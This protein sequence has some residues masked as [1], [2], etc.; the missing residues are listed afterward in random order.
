MKS[1]IIVICFSVI[2]IIN[3]SATAVT[4]T[5]H[6]DWDAPDTGSNS[7]PAFYDF[8]GDGDTDLLV[9]M[10]NGNMWAYKN[11]GSN[12]N[13]AWTRYSDWDAPDTGNDSS[14][15]FYDFDADGDTD[16]LA[17]MSTGRM[18]A[19]KNTGSDNDP[20]W[21]RYSD[22]DA[23]ETGSNASPAFYDFDGDGDTD[24]LVGMSN[25]N[26]WAYKNTGSD[27][28]PTWT[29]HSDWD[30]P[31]TGNDSTPAFYDFD[32][33]GDTDIL[34]GMSTGN[35]WAYEACSDYSQT[36]SVS[37]ST[38]LSFNELPSGDGHY[39]D[40]TFTNFSGSG[41][42]TVLETNMA[43]TNSP[44]KSPLHLRWD[45]DISAG[46][47]NFSCNVS[48]HYDDADV[49]GYPESSAYL[50]IAKYSSSTNTWQWVGGAVNADNNTVTVSGVTSFS[51]F[52]LFRRIFGDITG[53]G[54][55]DAADLQRLGDC[56]HATNSG[57]FTGGSD[58]R[59][60]NFNKNTDGGSQIIDAADLQ[61]F[62]DCWHN[63]IQP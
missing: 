11:T 30:A 51:T 8:D 48:F 29:R 3:Q 31:D 47:T 53:D 27:I 55:V 22:W 60:F 42:V 63:G 12:I 46:I 24:L 49:L 57:E 13:P 34:A 52:A 56:W 15:A 35:M 62:G 7:S 37:L 40:M 32:A 19:Y 28:D 21:T 61:V 2:V 36:L 59:F 38:V 10:S 43:Y 54:Y 20:T 33:D 5:R 41:N 14:P 18:W 45:I 1:L 6:S 50:G 39:I 26:M 17:G 9:G 44:C 58:A 25:G 23:P 4:W 16:I